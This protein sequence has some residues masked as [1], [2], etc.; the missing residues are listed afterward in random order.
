[1][2]IIGKKDALLAHAARILSASCLCMHGIG[3]T[4][5]GLKG[6]CGL[7]KFGEQQQEQIS[8]NKH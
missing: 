6:V 8:P 7:V 4:V 2:D 1:M 5:I 3:C